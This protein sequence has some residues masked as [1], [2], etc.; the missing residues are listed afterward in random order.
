MHGCQV[1]DLF[2]VQKQT[3]IVLL[4]TMTTGCC[5]RRLSQASCSPWSF[6]FLCSLFHVKTVH[7]IFRKIASR[8]KSFI[9]CSFAFPRNFL[10]H[11]DVLLAMFCVSV[12]KEMNDLPSSST[13]H[14][15]HS[16]R[17]VGK[18]VINNFSLYFLVLCLDM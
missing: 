10:R 18:T 11:F 7:P 13:G 1:I 17:S 12:E 5:K 15:C 3:S 8:L 2:H 14:S 6:A 16:L 4:V 9:L